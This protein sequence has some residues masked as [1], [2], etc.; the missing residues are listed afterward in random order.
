MIYQIAID[1]Y[2]SDEFNIPVYNKYTTGREC[3]YT[4]V[5]PKTVNYYGRRLNKM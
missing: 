3:E 4:F 2:N 5:Q 1:Y